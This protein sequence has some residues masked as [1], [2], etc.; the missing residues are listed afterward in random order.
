MNIKLGC[1]FVAMLGP[2]VLAQSYVTTPP[3]GT[4]L[5]GPD[6]TLIFGWAANQ[7]HRF[8]DNTH[9]GTKRSIKGVSFRSDYRNHNAI[10]R[11]WSRVMVMAAH[12]DFS[13]ISKLSPD[14]KLKDTPTRVFDSRWS[15]PALK[16]TPVL[17]PAQWGGVAGSLSFR[18]S[19]P[20]AYNGNDA[21]FLEWQFSGGVADNNVPW[22]GPTPRGFEYFLDSMT[23]SMWEGSEKPSRTYPPKLLPCYDSEFFKS[24]TGKTVATI[25][26]WLSGTTMAELVVA[27]NY[28][29]TKS[30]V[31]YAVGLAGNA[32]GLDLGAGCNLLHVDFTSP[33][34]LFYL[35]APN[36]K[37]AYASLTRRA[38]RQSWMKE[39]W[40][41]AAWADSQSQGL[42]LTHAVQATL[43][44]IKPVPVFASY[45][46]PNFSVWNQG[47][48][49]L[50]YMRYEY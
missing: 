1:V 8:M 47:Q 49:G 37:T 38:R 20:W 10:G 34:V 28:T 48:K 41:Q 43:G 31:L 25:D 40:V 36:N 35:P 15:F 12:G 33:T 32:Q 23:E 19:T 26:A 44:S 9:A 13:S 16:G 27:T 18:F 22:V 42:K 4:T 3:S 30:P 2:S 17:N 29:A 6:S 45:A 5:E 39:V 46:T 14:Y 21:I 50:P 24:G 11:T 7:G